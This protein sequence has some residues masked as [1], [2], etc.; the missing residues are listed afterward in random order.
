MN[1]EYKIKMALTEL[2]DIVDTMLGVMKVK[3]PEAEVIIECEEIMNKVK[4]EWY[5]VSF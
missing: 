3:I 2:L 1:D 5:P 4:K